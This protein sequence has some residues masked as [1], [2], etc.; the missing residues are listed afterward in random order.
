MNLNFLG[1]HRGRHIF[2]LRMTTCYLLK[3]LLIKRSHQAVVGKQCELGTGQQLIDPVAHGGAAEIRSMAAR[4]P[5]EIG[6]RAVR[7][8]ALGGGWAARFRLGSG[9]AKGAMKGLVE[10]LLHAGVASG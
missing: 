5:A 9:G 1:K 7:R 10:G 2:S 3:P 8:Q 6:P 4:L